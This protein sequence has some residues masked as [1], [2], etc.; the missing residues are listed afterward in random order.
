MGSLLVI[1][2]ALLFVPIHWFQFADGAA[3]LRGQEQGNQILQDLF[4]IWCKW[5]GMQIRVDKC[6]TFG[7][8][9]CSAKSSQFQPK[10]ANSGSFIPT[11]KTGE[12][13]RYL[14][15]HFEFNMSNNTHKSELSQLTNFILTDIGLLPLQPKTKLPFITSI[16]TLKLS[17]HS[18]VADLPKTWVCE[19]LDN[20]VVKYIR[21]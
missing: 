16:Y 20:V 15:S 18:T 9:K 19:H 7:I 3:V 14:G 13:F 6:V 4:C 17:W 21:K 5:P 11:V 2:L 1:V 12:S 8:I 10:L